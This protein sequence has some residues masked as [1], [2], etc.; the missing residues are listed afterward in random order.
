M[1]ASHVSFLSSVS[2]E[3]VKDMTACFGTLTII[4]KDNELKME[5]CK[6]LGE[7]I[8]SSGT[9]LYHKVWNWLLM[10]VS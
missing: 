4:V 6:A 8:G 10:C 5:H 2:P 7:L 1:L 9:S 3:M